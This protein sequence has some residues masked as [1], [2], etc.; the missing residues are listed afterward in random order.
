MKS[1]IYA[2]LKDITDIWYSIYEIVGK[3]DEMYNYLK[4]HGFVKS[5]QGFVVNMLHIKDFGESEIRMKNGVTVLMS[6]RRRLK[7]KE[8]YSD[9]INRRF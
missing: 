4:V 2:I 8:A 6:V 7:T 1:K 5:H 3:L 9:Y